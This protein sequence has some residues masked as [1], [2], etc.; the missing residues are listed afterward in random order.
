MQLINKLFKRTD[1]KTQLL[2]H[3]QDAV[4]HNICNQNAVSM[5]QGVL[6][7]ADIK[8]AD[9]MVPRPYMQ[10]ISANS[11]L[12]DIL[13][14]VIKTAHSRFPVIGNNSDDI[15]GILLAKD[16]L[17]FTNGN[18]DSFNL[19]DTLRKA[20]FIPENKRLDVLL[21]E[22]RKSRNHMAI[23]VD[24]YG[25]VT[26][27]IT[28]EDVLEQIVGAIDDEYD[29]ANTQLI[30]AY[31]NTTFSVKAL[32]TIE[33]FN[34]HFNSDLADATVDTI[35]GLVSKKF[36]HVPQRN[37]TISINNFTFKVLRAD[38][39]KVHLLRVVLS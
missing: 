26:G 33:E 11:K 35:G 28:I 18:A 31:N 16:L 15:K 13:P 38:N 27:L 4:K 1:P 29:V 12:A 34:N 8:V 22:F 39:K 10:V 6:Q 23:V 7:I 9:I 19:N 5:L 20:V 25:S 17:A 37:E 32:T 24:E 14:T 21:Q 3:I 36:G 2:R 30:Q